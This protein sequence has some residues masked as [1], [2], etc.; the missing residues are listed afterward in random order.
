VIGDPLAVRVKFPPATSM[1]GLKV[2]VVR[3]QQGVAIAAQTRE[4]EG[5]ELRQSAVRQRR[6]QHERAAFGFG[7]PPR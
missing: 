2:V 4:M 3:P 5:C 7:A 6:H 1:P